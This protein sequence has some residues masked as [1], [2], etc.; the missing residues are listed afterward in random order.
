MSA[1][2]PSDRP[3]HRGAHPEE[4]RLFGPKQVPHLRAATADLSWLLSRDYAGDR[5]RLHERQR[6]AVSRG[7]CSDGSREKRA[8]TKLDLA[9]SAD[10]SLLIDGFNLLITLEAALSGGVLLRGRDGCLRDM[11]SVHGSYRSVEE[12]EQALALVGEALALLRPAGVKWLLD[13]PISNSG[14]LAQTI[15]ELAEHRGWPWQVEAVFSPDKCLLESPEIA[16]TSDAVILNS[17][18]RWVDLNTVLVDE[19]VENAWV[20]D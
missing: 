6:L 8:R 14:H 15:R 16:V 20:V 2:S 18:A 19:Q 17:V 9:R 11:S 1:E 12:T 7:A 10:N 5:Y 4:R 3:R 13:R